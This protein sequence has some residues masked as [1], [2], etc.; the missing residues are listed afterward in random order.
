M[1]RIAWCVKSVS[2]DFVDRIFLPRVLPSIVEWD[3][4]HLTAP[5]PLVAKS[6]AA[7]I[8]VGGAVGVK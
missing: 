3:E 8:L 6:V 5:E 7:Y 4:A 1:L 2:L